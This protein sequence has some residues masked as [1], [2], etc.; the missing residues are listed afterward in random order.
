MK[1]SARKSKESRTPSLKRRNILISAVTRNSELPEARSNIQ[2]SGKVG[3]TR[4][5]SDG[6]HPEIGELSINLAIASCHME[7]KSFVFSDRGTRVTSKMDVQT[8]RCRDVVLIS[9]SHTAI[10]RFHHVVILAALA[11][12]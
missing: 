10:C 5:A 7:V 3:I 8:R 4:K 6:G 11:R 9:S 1:E 12:V 2:E